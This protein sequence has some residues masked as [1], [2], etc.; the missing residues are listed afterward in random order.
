MNGLVC[1]T[2]DDDVWKEDDLCF[3]SQFAMHGFCEWLYRHG[4]MEAATAA[5]ER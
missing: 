5:E 1:L 3:W 2:P 4:F